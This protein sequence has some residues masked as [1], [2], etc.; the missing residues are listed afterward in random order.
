MN[1]NAASNQEYRILKHSQ[2]FKELPLKM[3]PMTTCQKHTR[4]IVD[5]SF[6]FDRNS[7][8]TTQLISGLPFVSHPRFEVDHLA[9]A[10]PTHLAASAPQT[11][12]P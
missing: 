2:Q 3:R 12:Q 8:S 6:D 11:A 4:V 1:E 9:L 7:Y 5:E 10:A